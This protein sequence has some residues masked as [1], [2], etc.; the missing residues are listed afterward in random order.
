MIFEVRFERPDP[1]AITRRVR[2]DCSVLAVQSKIA[3]QPFDRLRVL[4]SKIKEF[5]PVLPAGTGT[6]EASITNVRPGPGGKCGPDRARIFCRRSFLQGR[7][8]QPAQSELRPTLLLLRAGGHRRPR[9]FQGRSDAG[10]GSTS[11]VCW[12]EKDFA[13]EGTEEDREDTEERVSFL[14]PQAFF[15]PVF[16]FQRW[17][18]RGMATTIYNSTAPAQPASSLNKCGTQRS[19]RPQRSQRKTRVGDF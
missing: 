6:S 8:I 12:W 15:P 2:G 1:E 18:T 17:L 7:I 16:K 11:F 4:G 13:T 14:K 9:R 5:P 3:N 10:Q 19:Q